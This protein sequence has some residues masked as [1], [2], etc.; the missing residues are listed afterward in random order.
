MLVCMARSSK[1]QLAMLVLAPSEQTSN[2]MCTFAPTQLDMVMFCSVQAG[3]I[4]VH[5]RGCSSHLDE[6]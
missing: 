1:T 2:K 4:G 3:R 6:S 5:L